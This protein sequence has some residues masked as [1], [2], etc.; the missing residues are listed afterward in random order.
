MRARTAAGLCPFGGTS[1][2]TGVATSMDS[3]DFTAAQQRR[4]Q[5]DLAA[6]TQSHEAWGLTLARSQLADI[7]TWAATRKLRCIPRVRQPRTLEC[8]AAEPAQVGAVWADA[9]ALTVV[10]DTDAA[11]FLTSLR[12][13]GDFAQPA[14]AAYAL[15]AI[16]QADAKKIG[17]VATQHAA[18][19]PDS[20]QAGL[21]SQVQLAF[22]RQDLYAHLSGTQLSGHVSVQHTLRLPS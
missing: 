22:H 10:I 6:S 12:V 14:V 13:V 15:N 11:G 7:S 21:L 18:I 19:T 17:G 3:A 5:G 16:E 1:A 4:S 8:K 9:Q 2:L 20:W